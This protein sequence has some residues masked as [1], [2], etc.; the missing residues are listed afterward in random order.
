MR[1]ARDIHITSEILGDIGDVTVSGTHV[2]GHV[3]SYVKHA[4]ELETDKLFL[5]IVQGGMALLLC[6]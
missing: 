4:P 6:G 2:S 1:L 3:F 5:G